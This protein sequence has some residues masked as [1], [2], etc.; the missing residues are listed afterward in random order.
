MPL[1]SFIILTLNEELNLPICLGSLR[2]LDAE[3]FV[4]DSGSVDRTAEIAREFGA[5]VVQHPFENQ[6]RQI[7]WALDNLHFSAPWIMRLDGDERLTPELRDELKSVLPAAPDTV[8][9]F[10]VKRR[11]YFWGRW[12]RHGGYYPVWLLRIWRH[13]KGRSEDRWLDEHIFVTEGKTRRLNADIIDENH[14]GLTFW[15]DKHNGFSDREVR[16]LL[17]VSD[18]S[19]ARRIGGQAGRKRILKTSLYAR[20]PLILR[21]F[22]YWFFRYFVLLGFLDGKAGF[23]FHFLQGL[24]YRVVVDAKLYEFERKSLLGITPRRDE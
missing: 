10:L 19:D 2:G 9:G 15:I 21:A 24:W 13:G 6:A 23:V 18:A 17:T 20:M 5:T 3:I 8:T 16:T 1:L 11:V 14:K 7:N 4:I 12:I 22:L